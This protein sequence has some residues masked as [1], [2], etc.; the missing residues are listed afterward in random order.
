MTATPHDRDRFTLAADDGL[1]IALQRQRP[2]GRALADVVYVH[3]AT[4]GADLSIYYAF[5]GRS[6]ADELADIGM[7][8]WGF[9]FVGYGAS[10]RYPAVA[11]KPAGDIDAAMRDLRCIVRAIRERNGDRPL[12]LLAHSRGG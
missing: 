9:D 4:F 6:W 8:V 12:V 11:D 10:S 5:D 3:G 2:Q 1:Q 7:T